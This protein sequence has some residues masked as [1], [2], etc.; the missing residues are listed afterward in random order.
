[1]N[2][3]YKDM[4]GRS[5]QLPQSRKWK[6]PSLAQIWLRHS[7]LPIMAT[8]KT[9]PITCEDHK[10]GL[11]WTLFEQLKHCP[12]TFSQLVSCILPSHFSRAPTCLSTKSSHFAKSLARSYFHN[13][14]KLNEFLML[15]KG[16][17]EIKIQWL[18]QIFQ[19]GHHGHIWQNLNHKIHPMGHAMNTHHVRSNFFSIEMSL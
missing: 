2:T 15:L 17:R 4:L 6:H 7:L 12:M 13:L 14:S 9:S 5:L 19:L 1:M 3:S 8:N 10:G 11:D 18:Q 16:A